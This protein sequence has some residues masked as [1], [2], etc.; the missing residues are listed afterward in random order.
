[1]KDGLQV[2]EDENLI[3]EIGP[4]LADLRKVPAMVKDFPG[5]KFTL[6]H[7]GAEGLPEGSAGLAE[8]KSLISELA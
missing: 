4:D 7:C 6:C 1:M 5:V 3:W 8:W 2:L